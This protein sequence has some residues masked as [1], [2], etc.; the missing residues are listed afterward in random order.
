MYEKT[1]YTGSWGV[2]SGSG[3]HGVQITADL[4]QKCHPVIS[5]TEYNKLD[6]QYC[7]QGLPHCSPCWP[8]TAELFCCGSVRGVRGFGQW[9]HISPCNF[10][11]NVCWHISTAVLLLQ[12]SFTGDQPVLQHGGL[13]LELLWKR[14]S[15]F[16]VLL[17][18]RYLKEKECIAK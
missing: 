10:C 6:L 18:L 1:Y 13:L 14:Q 2:L 17:P 8:E 15:F 16:Q 11:I 5:E 12:L 9:T 3:S 7:F 4:N